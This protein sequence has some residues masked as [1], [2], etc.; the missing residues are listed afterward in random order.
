MEKARVG[1]SSSTDDIEE[2]DEEEDEEEVDILCNCLI[3]FCMLDIFGP[4]N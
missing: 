1:A 3:M 4:S 2:E